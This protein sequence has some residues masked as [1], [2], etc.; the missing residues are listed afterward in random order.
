M[1]KT[2][3]QHMVFA[4]LMAIAMVYAMETY[5][6]ALQ[7]GGMR[8]QIFLLALK[9]LPAICLVVMI[10]EKTIGGPV[11]RKLAARIVNPEQDKPIFIIL[12]NAACMVCIMCPLMSL[13]TTLLFQSPGKE[14]IAI[15]LET[16]AKNFPMALCWQIFFAGPIVRFLFRI[17]FK[18]QLQD[19]VF[20]D[21]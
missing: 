7:M 17:I 9:D 5:H 8:N 21:R 19:A 13:V 14:I 16:V 18:K 4:I 15:W 3:M 10:L 2:K 20:I 6:L 11:A 1:P 12:V